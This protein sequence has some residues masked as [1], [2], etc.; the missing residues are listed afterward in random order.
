[1]QRSLLTVLFWPLVM[2][3]ETAPS[4]V[5]EPLHR[6][7]APG[8][9]PILFHFSESEALTLDDEGNLLIVRGGE[10][11][12]QRPPA[13]FQRI[14]GSMRLVSAEYVIGRGGEVALQFGPH[15]R[16]H[17]LEIES[18]PAVCLSS[19]PSAPASGHAGLD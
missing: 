8:T 16:A 3:A 19:V 15:D 14:G 10:T 1:M 11:L 2:A 17:P 4:P 5:F 13:V 9:R 6:T 12:V 7:V 18:K